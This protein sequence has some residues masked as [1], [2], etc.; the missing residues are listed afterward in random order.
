MTFE[1]GTKRP[2]P[3]GVRCS[4]RRPEPVAHDSDPS[5]CCVNSPGRPSGPLDQL[6]AA[7]FPGYSCSPLVPS[8][9]V[10]SDHFFMPCKLLPPLIILASLPMKMNQPSAKEAVNLLDEPK[11]SES[12]PVCQPQIRQPPFTSH[13]RLFQVT[14]HG[15]KRTLC[16]RTCKVRTPAAQKWLPL[17]GTSQSLELMPDSPP[18]S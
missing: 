4:A 6:H 9:P 8:F 11:S 10:F 13:L 14:K 7:P 3:R 5:Q 17:P 12:D 16:G 15:I 18:P 2:F 1:S